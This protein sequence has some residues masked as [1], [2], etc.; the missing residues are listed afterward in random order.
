MNF[1]I[2]TVNKNLESIHKLENEIKS[3]KMTVSVIDLGKDYYSK[4]LI[5]ELTKVDDY[6]NQTKSKEE[7][8]IILNRI[9]GI[10]YD[11]TDLDYLEILEKNNPNIKVYNNPKLS[12]LFRDKSLQ[13][14]FYQ[15][16]A[17]ETIPTIDIEFNDLKEI[18][19]FVYDYQAPFLLKPKRSNQGK[20]I[21]NTNMP[22]REIEILTEK[23][24]TRYIL[25]PSLKKESE[26]RLLYIDGTLKSA[27]L[28]RHSDPHAILNCANANLTNISLNDVPQTVQ[29]IGKI[30]YSKAP[31]KIM[32][33]D[34]LCTCDGSSYL[35]ETNTVP[36]MAF[37]EKK[38]NINVSSLL[39]ASILN[40][41]ST[42]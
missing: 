26:W 6:F 9:S 31:L 21:I 40:E 14:K 13:N 16:H 19:K 5:K 39:V 25:Q 12:R 3:Q 8:T 33:L 27:L 23:K 36:G 10:S 2:L 28:K 41:I 42:T 20:G 1:L 32:A 7:K 35:I 4:G 34:I 18:E 29:N 15:S 37:V 11:D 30:V 38:G 22:L 17:I 24:D